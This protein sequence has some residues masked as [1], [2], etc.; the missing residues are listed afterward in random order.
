MAT[1]FIQ[2]MEEK[3]AQVEAKPQISVEKQ[4]ITRK[5]GTSVLVKDLV[6]K[7]NT[8][9]I[10][11]RKFSQLTKAQLSS[12]KIANALPQTP[13]S[14]TEQE[15]FPAVDIIY[16]KD[17][18]YILGEDEYKQKNIFSRPASENENIF[19][20]LPG[21]PV[22]RF[23]YKD[24]YFFYQFNEKR[25]VDLQISP[26]QKP[27]YP[28]TITHNTP[29]LSVGIIEDQIFS[30]S[31]WP[32]IKKNYRISQHQ[33]APSLLKPDAFIDNAYLL[34]CQDNGMIIAKIDEKDNTKFWVW[35]R[36][37]KKNDVRVTLYALFFELD[38][39]RNINTK[40]V[41][42]VLNEAEQHIT[43]TKKSF[44]KDNVTV[45]TLA[46][47]VILTVDQQNDP[48]QKFPKAAI[49]D[50]T[51]VVIHT[52]Q[53]PDSTVYAA[54][55]LNPLVSIAYKDEQDKWKTNQYLFDHWIQKKKQISNG[56]IRLPYIYEIKDIYLTK[57]DNQDTA[58]LVTQTDGRG[59]C[60]DGVYAI[61][62]T[63]QK[64]D[65]LPEPF[66][67]VDIKY[68]KKTDTE[69]RRDESRHPLEKIVAST[70]DYE[71]KNLFLITETFDK[72]KKQELI[73]IAINAAI[74][75]P[76]AQNK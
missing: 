62:L 47:N 20:L 53:Y 37:N 22:T 8:S 29:I 76:E 13:R 10:R 6:L 11:K 63:G 75:K 66:W 48:L 39:I 3:S 5:E 42:A 44:T 7:K 21:L 70:F 26:T 19:N 40:R 67:H 14:E 52:Q 35:R 54:S 32:S 31:L 36:F 59:H 60:A 15:H 41:T 64:K 1:S 23:F 17:F 9:N 50:N 33:K 65:A 46:K 49:T 74:K 27:L 69:G 28:L 56:Y 61:L 2:G 38:S 4:R 16:A 55:A 72:D 34:A 51:A 25:I 68:I 12:I 45:V 43:S 71:K 24:S 30:G 57:I 58:L 73:T 18:L